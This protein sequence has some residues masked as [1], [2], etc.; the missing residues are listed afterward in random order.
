ML[1]FDG[2]DKD[3]LFQLGDFGAAVGTDVLLY[4]ILLQ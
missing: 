1:R 2:G 3:L 4:D